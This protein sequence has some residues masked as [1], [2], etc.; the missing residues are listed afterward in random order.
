MDLLYSGT[1]AKSQLRAFWSLQRTYYVIGAAVK[2]LMLYYVRLQRD[3]YCD[4]GMEQCLVGKSVFLFWVLQLE[5]QYCCCAALH[6]IGHRSHRSSSRVVVCVVLVIVWFSRA[7]IWNTT[8]LFM[9][10]FFW[11]WILYKK[12]YF[13]LSILQ[14]Q[15]PVS[16]LMKP[17]SFSD[18]MLDF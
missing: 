8:Y 7:R 9:S 2:L 17:F 6:V 12:F 14:V 13:M 15:L 4:D 16:I 18:I 11:G 5:L 10:M 3:T 1:F